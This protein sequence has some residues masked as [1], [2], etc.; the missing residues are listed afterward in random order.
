MPSTSIASISSR[1]VRE[2]RS[3]HIAVAPAPATINTVTSGPSWVTA[4]KAAP[5]PLRSAAPNSR[6]RMLRMKL[7]RTVNGMAT[8]SVGA[9]ATRATN[10]ACSKNSRA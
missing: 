7:T 3:A 5:A 1:M 8:N 10:Q 2:P 6:N 4:P 9:N